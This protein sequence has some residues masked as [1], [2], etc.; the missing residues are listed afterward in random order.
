[1]YIVTSGFKFVDVDAFACICAYKEFLV[2]RGDQ[3]EAVITSTLNA[4]ITPRYRSL[5]FYQKDL[6]SLGGGESVRFVLLDVSD[7][8]YFET[9]VDREKVSD[10]IDHHPG[11]E[12][13][14]RERIGSRAVIEPIGAAATLVYRKYKETGLLEKMTSLSAELLAVAILSNTLNFRARITT[15]EDKGAYAHLKTLFGASDDFEER[16]LSDVQVGIERDIM[17]ALEYD[18]KSLDPSLFIGQIEVWDGEDFYRRFEGDIH[19]FLQKKENTATFMN[20]IGLRD[21][22]NHIVFRD[23]TSLE[24]LRAYFPEFAYDADRFVA[25]TPEVILRKEILARIYEKR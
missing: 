19:A 11:Y 8:E 9:F 15:Q 4:S 12:V 14:W 13:Y 24:Y 10:V 21:G 20:V 6:G 23:K 7:P 16:Y 25:I 22:Q 17:R 2:L 1:M 3:A 5:N 18:G